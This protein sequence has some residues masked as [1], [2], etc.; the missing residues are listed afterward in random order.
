LFVR[1]NTS[2]LGFA[3]FFLP[4]FVVLRIARPMVMFIIKGQNRA[5]RALIQGLKDGMFGAG[6]DIRG[7]IKVLMSNEVRR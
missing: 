1:K 2:K 3:L 5:S 7:R 6:K 4:T